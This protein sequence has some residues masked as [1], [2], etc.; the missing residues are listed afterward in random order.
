VLYRSEGN[1]P[2]RAPGPGPANTKYRRFQALPLLNAFVRA[3]LLSHP[4]L[5]TFSPCGGVG[6]GMARH[7]ARSTQVTQLRSAC[8][9]EILVDRS[10][11][12]HHPG[13][14][15]FPVALYLTS[16]AAGGDRP[17]IRTESRTPLRT[18]GG[19]DVYDK[20]VGP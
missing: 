11:L 13:G 9:A 5:S 3:F 8:R 12:R 15:S 14:A 4:L 19:V 16:T 7:D 18:R 20:G 6:G 2:R 10:T 1:V 17:R